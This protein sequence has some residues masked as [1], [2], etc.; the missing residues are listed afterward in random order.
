MTPRL[1]AAELDTEPAALL[2]DSSHH[3]IRVE[4]THL[5][6]PIHSPSVLNMREKYH[7]KSLCHCN[8]LSRHRFQNLAQTC[9]DS[10]DPANSTSYHQYY[11]IG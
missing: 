10:L 6:S 1:P 3:L 8:L 9:H 11:E 5:V 2:K 7:R 4:Q